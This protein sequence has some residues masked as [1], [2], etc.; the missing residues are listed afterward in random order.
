MRSRLYCLALIVITLVATAE[1]PRA[2]SAPGQP[3]PERTGAD[4]AKQSQ[5]PIANLISLPIQNNTYF[6]VGPDDRTANVLNIQPVVPIKLG[7]WNVINR[8]IL[9][10]I[11]VEDL[12]SGLDVL[13]QGA[14]AGSRFGL[15][16]INYT[17]FFSPPSSGGFT[18]G[19][20]PSINIP[21]ATN[22]A[23][24]TEKWS[25]G[26]SAVVVFS[27]GKWV[28]GGLVRQLWSFAGDDD[29][30][31]VNQA[32]LQP[33][34]NYNLEDGWALVSS[35]II[36]ANWQADSDDRWTIPVGGGVSKLFTV[37]AQPVTATAQVYYNVE[38]PDFAPDW[39]L[40][41]GI[42]FLFPK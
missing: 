23:I 27:P 34:I 20:G 15:G 17:A 41:I 10:V 24:G 8:A 2:Q 37:G 36:A 4:L 12:T 42:S 13:P 32:I 21:T 6:G 40:R 9:P 38:R 14:D 39:Q 3:S 5:N 28:L 35:P 18:W 25:L 11:H 30:Q 33:I 26:P 22:R 29:R 31:D 1:D 7:G 19:I 16:D